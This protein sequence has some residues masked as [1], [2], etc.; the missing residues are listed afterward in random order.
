MQIFI[1]FLVLFIWLWIGTYG[2]LAS[3][4]KKQNYVSAAWALLTV[5]IAVYI[6][7]ALTL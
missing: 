3:R 6:L 4:K 2:F 1:T 7:S 5:V